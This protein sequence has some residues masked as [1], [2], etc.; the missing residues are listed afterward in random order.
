MATGSPD[1]P[2]QSIQAQHSDHSVQ[3]MPANVRA[4]Q[5]IGLVEVTGGL[6][7]PIDASKLAEEFGGDIATLLP[8]IDTAELLGLVRAEKGAV[9]LTDYGLKF[10]RL[11]KKKVSM[12]KEQI[13]RIEPFKTAVSIGL[14]KKSVSAHDVAEALRERDI[15][16]HHTPELNE[17][18]IQGMLIHWA[19]YAGILTYNGKTSKFQKV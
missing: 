15:R 16:W 3:V 1:H 9:H 19:I 8:I 7:S 4:G 12:L 18:L 6:G 11:A 14:S 10:Q 2:K 13:S 5:V 17:A